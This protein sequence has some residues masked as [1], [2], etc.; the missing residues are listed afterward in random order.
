[1]LRYEESAF[2]PAPADDV[3]AYVDDFARLSAH[4]TKRSW[5]M[6]GSSMNVELDAG[7]GSSI[8]SKIRMSGRLLGLPLALEEVVIDRHPPRNK[9]WMT[10]GAPNLI[11]IANYRMGFEV[12]S[13]GTEA[14]LRV[15]IEYSLPPRPPGSW[16]GRMLGRS[17]ARWCV[18]R[19]ISDTVR[20]FAAP[21]TQAASMH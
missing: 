20:H 19:M 5:I 3:F 11:V 12:T 15:Y 17:Y 21:V 9:S 13:L 16:L 2:I 6:L 1:M 10:T 14:R 7:Q 8:G 18:R 4:M